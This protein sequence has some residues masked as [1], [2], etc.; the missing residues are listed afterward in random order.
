MDTKSLTN[1]PNSMRKATKSYKLACNQLASFFKMNSSFTTTTGSGNTTKSKYL[2]EYKSN[3][4][5]GTQNIFRRRYMSSYY[6][7]PSNSS[8]PLKRTRH[9]ISNSHNLKEIKSATQTTNEIN[10]GIDLLQKKRQQ[11]SAKPKAFLKYAPEEQLTKA[12]RWF[13]M[14]ISVVRLRS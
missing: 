6:E 13:H 9:T 11:F 2:I 10:E 7:R 8:S 12:G 1:S 14:R 3:S 5:D 4:F